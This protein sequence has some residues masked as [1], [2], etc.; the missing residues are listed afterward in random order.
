[1]SSEG[2][3]DD[4]LAWQK[5][6]DDFMVGRLQRIQ[7][8]AQTWLSV[9]TSLL[10]LFSA[11]VVVGGGKSIKEIPGGPA[12]RSVL[13]GWAAIVYIIAA[14]AV[15][16]AASATFGGLSIRVEGTDSRSRLTRL[17][18][19][20]DPPDL[21]HWTYQN[22]RAKCVAQAPKARKRLHR[23]RILGLAAAGLSGA[24]AFTVLAL[25]TFLG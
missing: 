21:S 6:F 1:M 18:T 16:Y 20:V 24:L 14:A 10:S 22:Y 17:W 23:A 5:A 11:A 3:A 25:S 2:S 19:P 9:I 15:V 4:A 13:F 7:S 12:W 8:S